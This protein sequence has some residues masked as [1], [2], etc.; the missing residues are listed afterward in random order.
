MRGELGVGLQGLVCLV[1]VELQHIFL[2]F[3]FFFKVS[4]SV[5]NG[6]ITALAKA[7]D[8]QDLLVGHVC[9]LVKSNSE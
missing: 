1:V 9:L 7:L 4:C 5:V 8:F 6:T 3:F 2:L